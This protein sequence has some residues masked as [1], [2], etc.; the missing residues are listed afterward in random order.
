MGS[1]RN[2]VRETGETMDECGVL[3]NAARRRTRP[4]V[5]MALLPDDYGR[6]ARDAVAPV[7]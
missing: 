6:G 3:Q 2:E 7:A 5:A 1:C 4:R